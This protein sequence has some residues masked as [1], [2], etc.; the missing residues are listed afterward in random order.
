MATPGGALSA[1]AAQSPKARSAEAPQPPK[2][3]EY[4][5]AWDI[6]KNSLGRPLARVFDPPRLLRRLTANEMQALNV[7][8]HDQ[9]RLP[10]TW[11]QPRVGFR[12]VTPEQMLRGPGSGKGPAP[13]RWT[14]TK[15]K[16]Q[17]LT[18]GFQIKDRNGDKFLIKFDPPKFPEMASGAEV[19]G[20]YLFWAAGYNVPD[21]ALATFRPESLDIDDKA[22]Y[23]DVMGHKKQFD[24]KHLD[25]M[26]TK[27][28][29]RRDGSFRC[30]ASRFLEGKPLGPF[31]YDGRRKDDPEDLVP[32][33]RRRELRGL[34]AVAAWTN[35]AD[36]RGP[37]SLDMWV[38][39][40]GRSFVRHYLIDFGSVL[41]SS[42]VWSRSPATGTEYYLDFNVVFP[43]ILTLG[44]IPH[45]WE[46][47]YDPQIPSVGA[48]EASA[49]DP[50]T[51]RPDYPNPAFDERHERDVRWGARIVGAFTD[52]Q[53]R[54]AVKAAQYTDARATE[55]LTHVL[56]QRR[57]KIARAWPAR[58]PDS[59][60]STR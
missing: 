12:T 57:D 30:L 24:R 23:T 42:A 33:E 9:V 2:E 3:H 15:A 52:D 32:H 35:H 20:T 54:A 45:A 46:A 10:S 47:G 29:K 21:N 1:T 7:D 58:G 16:T 40:N 59:V 22:T 37:N 17:G 28:A 50:I 34:W 51:W 36:I 6:A 27:V 25:D 19:I 18:P 53:I 11:W 49:F 14:V 60:S 43:T 41:G 8:E 39:E 44:L 31:S 4:S 48:V 56:I 5:Y 13:G 38:T 26:L 55:Y